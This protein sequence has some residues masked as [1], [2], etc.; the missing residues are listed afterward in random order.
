[1]GYLIDLLISFHL[2]I[3]H[4]DIKLPS[5]LELLPRYDPTSIFT[6]MQRLSS[7]AGKPLFSESFP[8]DMDTTSVAL[9]VLRPD[10][11]L[12]NSILDEMLEYVDADGIMQV[13]VSHGL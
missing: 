1:M 8:D 11:A 13:W 10:R 3:P 12:V 2:Q 9:T 6:G 4:H 5:H 7:L